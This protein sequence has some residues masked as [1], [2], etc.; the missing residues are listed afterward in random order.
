VTADL[1][2]IDPTTVDID[3]D[4]ELLSIRAERTSPAGD[5]VTWLSHERQA[6]SFLR[7]LTLG[8]NIDTEKIAARCDNGVL[9]LTLPV[10]EKARARKSEI[11]N[12]SVPA[13]D[14]AEVSAA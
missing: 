4:G 6:R 3:V 14:A 7:Q 13:A 5:N 11:S 8:L 2:G 10:S 12:M 1:P 9:D